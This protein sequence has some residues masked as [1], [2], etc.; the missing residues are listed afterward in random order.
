MQKSAAVIILLLAGTGTAKA[1][2][3]LLFLEVQ[4]IAGYSSAA[5]KV[6][7]Y[8]ADRHDAMQKNSVGFDYLHKFSGETGDTATAALQARLAYNDGDDDFTPQIYNAYFKFKTRGG[9]I[10]LGHNRPA[11]GL[12]SYWDTHAELI[13][14]LTMLGVGYDRDWGIGYS[15]DTANGNI[16]STLTSGSG[17]NYRA[18]GNW[19]SATRAAYGVLNYD[20]YT[21]GVSLMFGK[22]LDVMGYD[23]MDRH[24]KDTWLLGW[25]GAYNVNNTEHKAEL[26]AGQRNHKPYYAALYR[27]GIRP[28]AEERLT[29][30]F[31]PAYVRKEESENWTL[32]GGASYLL[33]ADLTMR[34]M[35]QYRAEDADNRYI[36]Q[37]Y[38]YFPI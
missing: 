18:Y 7:Y 6:V 23:I 5:R 19:M 37:L 20:N 14:D 9:D 30:E 8:S 4:G 27:F 32:S 1:G 15:Y 31:Q 13:G 22:T 3:D 10:W 17:M 36:A 33:T 26:A 16:A 12:S 11:F 38:W 28:D 34:L 2:S 25:D 35:Y 21:T 29:L 24:P